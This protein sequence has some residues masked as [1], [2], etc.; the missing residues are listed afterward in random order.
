MSGNGPRKTRARLSGLEFVMMH[1][2]KCDPGSVDLVKATETVKHGLKIS[3]VHPGIVF[4]VMLKKVRKSVIVLQGAFRRHL[5]RRNL[6]FARILKKWDQRALKNAPDLHEIETIHA[7][8]KRSKRLSLYEPSSSSKEAISERMRRALESSTLDLLI[9]K[10]T[11]ATLFMETVVRYYAMHKEWRRKR[12][13]LMARAIEAEEAVQRKVLGL[14]VDSIPAP[15][16]FVFHAGPIALQKMYTG[17]QAN[18][19]KKRVEESLRRLDNPENAKHGVKNI[20]PAEIWTVQVELYE[21]LR[22]SRPDITQRLQ[23][24]DPTPSPQP[25]RRH[26]L[27]T[28][29]KR[30]LLT[31]PEDSSHGVS[32]S[33]VGI[34]LVPSPGPRLLQPRH[35]VPD[36]GS[37]SKSLRRGSRGQFDIIGSPTVRKRQSLPILSTTASRHP[38]LGRNH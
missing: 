11:V 9:Q 24:Q 4:G 13:V 34:P 2:L 21:A 22:M 6:M 3:T 31:S 8:A 10:D 17:K 35:S 37:P 27:G 18:D 15:P 36:C 23:K 29:S 1:S 12:Q 14:E 28:F 25:N 38:P 30:T 19:N 16:E 26:S 33:S 7:K 20:V 32:L 5:F